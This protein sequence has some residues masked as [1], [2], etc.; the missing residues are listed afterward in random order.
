MTDDINH[1]AA[2]LHDQI[3]QVHV[4]RVARENEIVSTFEPQLR[5][6][7]NRINDIDLWI[8]ND[9]ES[10]SLRQRK[11]VDIERRLVDTNCRAKQ[12][13]ENI[14]KAMERQEE[15]NHERHCGAQDNIFHIQESLGTRLG[16]MDKASKESIEKVCE[17]LTK[18]IATEQFTRELTVTE[19]RNWMSSWR[20]DFSK[21]QQAAIA[22]HEKRVSKL[23]N[24]TREDLTNLSATSDD[25]AEHL[26]QAIEN[27]SST[28]RKTLQGVE[29][30]LVAK[31]NGFMHK[32]ENV[33][34]AISYATDDRF[35]NL[36]EDLRKSSMYTETTSLKLVEV[37]YNINVLADDV[38]KLKKHLP[39]IFA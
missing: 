14:Q 10:S 6:S 5:E 25:K 33:S 31:L 13:N 22:D 7:L 24:D 38:A 35:D 11:L 8:K 39:M 32:F 28:W 29:T 16:D 17:E 2:S 34:T 4:E 3:V 26:I 23:I 15:I 37:D 21:S 12:S 36:S 18:L 20:D 1:K 27:E 19:Q 9:A 30:D